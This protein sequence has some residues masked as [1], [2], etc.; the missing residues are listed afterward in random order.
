MKRRWFVLSN[1]GPWQRRITTIVLLALLVPLISFAPVSHLIPRAQPALLELAAEQPDVLAQ[2][3]VR[4]VAQAKPV[5]TEVV[6]LGGQITRSLEMINGFAAI[7]PAK[8][9]PVVARLD[10]VAWISL[11]APVV[12]SACPKCPDAGTITS[13]Y[14]QTVGVDRVWQEMPNMARRGLAVAVIDSG[15]ANHPDLGFTAQR[16]SRLRVTAEFPRSPTTAGD[17]FGHGTHVAG[18]VA[19]NGTASGGRITGVAPMVNVI[20]VKVTDDSGMATMSDLMNGLQWVYENAQRHNIRVVNLSMNSV[21][22]ESYHT[23][24]LSAALELLWMRGIM[25]VVAAGNTGNGGIYPPANDPFVITVGAA[26]DRGTSN[27]ADDVVADF[28][29]RGTTID[30]FSKPDLV[31]PGRGIVSLLSSPDAV[32]AQESP[33]NVQDNVYFRMS[34]T[35]VAAPIVAGSIALL[36]A[37]EPQ[38]NPD[39]VKA[40]LMKTARPMASAGAGAGMLDAYASITSEE[41]G[42]AND[43]IML[44]QLLWDAADSPIYYNSRAWTSD[45]SWTSRNWTS[46][47]WTS[48]SWTSGAWGQLET[49]TSRA[50]TSQSIISRAWTSMS[51]QSVGA[52]S[53]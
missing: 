23:S 45:G 2:V 4:K 43:G 36:L 25:V 6:R 46:R 26:D 44:S 14:I 48:R 30:G 28:S 34:G 8:Q 42:N 18:I 39:Q 9:I 33:S 1:M 35:S 38:L 13:A 7:L 12:S 49:W 15:V 37:D 22:E 20:N 16:N 19:G 31:A 11:D 17:R 53:E 21:V 3:I 41:K 47:S 5:E 50:W 10:G 40:R 24:P 29:S 51:I 52:A 32:I 27:P